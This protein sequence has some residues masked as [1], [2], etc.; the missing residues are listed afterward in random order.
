MTKT[1]RIFRRFLELKKKELSEFKECAFFLLFVFGLGVGLF[2][3]A[4][5]WTFSPILACWLHG[6]G[7]V[8]FV[9]SWLVRN[10]FKAKK[11]IEEEDAY[12]HEQ[13]RKVPLKGASLC[14]EDRNE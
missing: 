12:Y 7:A 5:L 10:W 4:C 13:F 1:K 8:V 3:Y 6:V 11:Q 2:V 14:I 9:L